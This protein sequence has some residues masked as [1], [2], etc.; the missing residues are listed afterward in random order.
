MLRV[1][2]LWKRP[3]RF[4]AVSQPLRIIP[5][6]SSS[7]HNTSAPV[8]NNLARA[9]GFLLGKCQAWRVSEPH[10]YLVA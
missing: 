6:A 10:L 3:Y 5:D 4:A 9:K 1:F 8:A 2:H 7:S